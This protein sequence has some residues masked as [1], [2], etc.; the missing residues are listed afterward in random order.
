MDFIRIINASQKFKIKDDFEFIEFEDIVG[1]EHDQDETVPQSLEIWAVVKVPYEG[2]MPESYKA[3]NLMIGDWAEKNEAPLTKELHEKLK[4]HLQ[5]TFPE[6][7]VS[8]LDQLD[9]SV[10]WLD[11]LDYMPIVDENTSTMTIEIELVLNVEYD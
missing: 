2:E 11:Q 9:N 7:D 3:L 6:G 10:V 1:E 4:G 8:D 5:K